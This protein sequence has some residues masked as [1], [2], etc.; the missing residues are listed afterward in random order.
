[1]LAIDIDDTLADTAGHT[2]SI[3]LEKFGSPENLS[4]PDILKKYGTIAAVPYWQTP[5]ILAFRDAQS[6]SSEYQEEIPLIPGAKEGLTELARQGLLTCYLTTRPEEAIHGT[7]KWMKKHGLPDLPIIYRTKAEKDIN[8]FFWKAEYLKQHFPEIIALVDNSTEQVPYL[9]GYPGT[10]F[11]FC[12][13]DFDKTIDMK[14]IATPTWQAVV[15]ASKKA[16]SVI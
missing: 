4:A 7:K 8:G 5:D 15:E 10:L 13:R 9:E 2:A 14:V 1:M 16:K 6:Y 3:L 12:D 11:L